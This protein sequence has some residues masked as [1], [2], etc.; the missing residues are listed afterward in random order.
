MPEA[1]TEGECTS[2]PD[3]RLIIAGGLSQGKPLS[4]VACFTPNSTSEDATTSTGSWRLI[5]PMKTPHS[6]PPLMALHGGI[7][8]V[9]ANG[10][11]EVLNP[12]CVGDY[13]S[14]GQWTSIRLPCSSLFGTHKSQTLSLFQRPVLAL[15]QSG[16]IYAFGRCISR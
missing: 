13:R 11:V 6:R 7:L 5:A 3:G 16:N 2:L 9:V 14:Q 4:S 12:P 1:R 15:G 8:L 10:S